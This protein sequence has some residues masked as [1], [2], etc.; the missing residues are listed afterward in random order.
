M[1]KLNTGTAPKTYPAKICLDGVNSILHPDLKIAAALYAAHSTKD[2]K[3]LLKELLQGKAVEV[4]VPKWMTSKTFPMRL[5]YVNGYDEKIA[6]PNSRYRLEED[7]SWAVERGG[8]INVEREL[9]MEK[10]HR[11]FSAFV[12]WIDE[13]NCIHDD[14][15]DGISQEIKGGKKKPSTRKTG[16]EDLERDTHFNLNKEMVNRSIEKISQGDEQFFCE[17]S[18]DLIWE[19]WKLLRSILDVK[20]YLSEDWDVLSLI[21]QKRGIPDDKID[22]ILDIAYPVVETEEATAEE[23]GQSQN[24]SSNNQG[25]NGNGQKPTG[26]AGKHGQSRDKKKPDRNNRGQHKSGPNP[27]QNQNQGRGQDK[28]EPKTKVTEPAVAAEDP[29]E[30]EFMLNEPVKEKTILPSQVVEIL[31]KNGKTV[32]VEIAGL[33]VNDNEAMPLSEMNKLLVA[34]GLPEIEPKPKAKK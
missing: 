3:E 16:G 14:S 7:Q 12:E 10:F 5:C 4:D 27:S 8:T 31:K 2:G 19:F 23:G 25:K 20:G 24:G 15:L 1:E 28:P 13:N 34:A 33:A 11:A 30:D 29:E 9:N 26:G 22:Q 17:F 32:P 18:D 21:L 6:V